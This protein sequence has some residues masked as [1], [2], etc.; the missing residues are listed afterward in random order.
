MHGGHAAQHGQAQVGRWRLAVVF[1]PHQRGRGIVVVRDQA[2]PVPAVQFAGLCGNVRLG[3]A[4]VQ[5]GRQQAIAIFG[6]HDAIPAS[7]ELIDQGAVKAGEPP[8]VRGRKPAQV[9]HRRCRFN[10]GHQ[11]ADGWIQFFQRAGLAGNRC[12]QL[13]QKIRGGAVHQQLMAA[14]PIQV[15]GTDMRAAAHRRLL[16]HALERCQH[17]AQHFTD[18][19][20]QRF[21]E[22][23]QQPGVADGALAYLQGLRFNDQK[24][25][26]G[27][28]R[29]RG[30][31]RFARATGQGSVVRGFGRRRQGRDS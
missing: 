29:A 23:F 31:D 24:H 17:A 10:A 14:V 7:I 4:Q 8:H 6:H 19:L 30:V 28:D 12:F 5:V 2:H 15:H 21:A 18:V 16:Q 9:F 22:L 27:L 13:D 3:K 26:V 1:G 20:H 11:L 25:T